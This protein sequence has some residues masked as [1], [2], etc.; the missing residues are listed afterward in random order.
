MEEIISKEELQKI[1]EIKG[2]VTGACI[3]ND[4]EFIFRK[5]GKEGL[6][7]LE[8]AMAKLGYQLKYKELKMLDLYSAQIPVILII[9]IK[10]LFNYDNKKFQ[11]MG[12]AESKISPLI[13]RLYM[14]YF[15]SPERVAKELPKMWDKHYKIGRIKVAEF[16]KKEKYI[17]LR[18]EDFRLHPFI[19]QVLS[20]Y[21]AGMLQMIFKEQGTCKET[22]CIFQGDECHEFLLEW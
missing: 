21:F 9:L 15:V 17:I 5:E 18:I 19:C 12:M 13:I 6:K 2:E 11:E 4:L 1:K 22:K 3:A 20:G 14:K 16:N 7:K 10:K 8:D